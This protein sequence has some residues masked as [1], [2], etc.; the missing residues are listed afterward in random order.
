M[1]SVATE[2][3]QPNEDISLSYEPVL[4]RV[5]KFLGN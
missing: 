1:K 3:N 5:E 4:I 2:D